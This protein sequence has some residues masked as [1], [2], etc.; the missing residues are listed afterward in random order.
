MK[1]INLVLLGFALSVMSYAQVWQ[2]DSPSLYYVSEGEKVFLSPDY[3]SYAIYFKDT[4]S[5]SATISMKTLSASEDV[6]MLATKS[7]AIVKDLKKPA[8]IKTADQKNSFLVSNELAAAG[9]YDVLP[10]FTVLGQQVWF[11]KRVTLEL[12]EGYDLAD[13]SSLLEQYDATFLRNTLNEKSFLLEVEGIENQLPLIQQLSEQGYLKWGHPDFRVEIVHFNDPLF[14]E[15]F[16][17]NNTGGTLDGNPLV[18]D[19]DIDALEAWGI[20]TGTSSITVSVIDDGLEAHPDLPTISA[21]Y[22]PANNGDGTPTTSTDGH[23]LA[24]GGIIAAQHDNGI[25]VRGVAPG[26]DLIAVNIFQGSETTQDLADA[27]TWSV[28]QGADVISNS[29]GYSSCTFNAPTLTAAINSAATTGRNGLGCVILFASGNDYGS[30]VSYPAN[31]SNVIAVGALSPDGDISLYS[32]QGSA[33]DVV[34]PSNDVNNAVTAFIYGVRT[35]DRVGSNGYSTGEYTTSFGGTSAACPAAAGAAALVLSVDA[36]LTKDQ[37]YTLLTTT[38]DDMGGAGF[39]NT[40]GY[41]RVNAYQAVIAA[42]GISCSLAAP[43]SFT[44][45]NVTDTGFDLSWSAVS[46]AT[47]YTLIIDGSSYA[48]SGTS[49]SATG[50]TPGTTYSCVVYGLCSN[51]GIGSSA[52]LDVTTTGSNCV[53][54]PASM[55]LITDNYGSETTWTLSVDGS[56]VASG[57]PYANNTTYNVSFDYGDGDYD[58]VISDSYGDGICCAYGTGSYTITDG[59]GS[60]IAAGGEF[61]TTDAVS[62]CIEGGSGGGGGCTST[63]VDSNDFESGWGIWNDGGSDCRRSSNDASYSNGTYSIRLRDN[64]NSSVMT[65]DNL[66]L[67]SFDDLTVSF[68][69]YARSMDNSNE[70]FWLQISTDGGSSYTLVE[71]WNLN[72]E[73]VNNVREDDAV[74]IAGPFTSTTR[75][76]FRCDASGNSDWVY[77]DDVEISGC[78]TGTSSVSLTNEVAIESP[79]MAPVALPIS[80][81]PNPVRSVVNLVNVPEQSLVRVLSVSGGVLFEGQGVSQVDLSSFNSGLYILQ[82]Q[83]DDLSQTFRLIKE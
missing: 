50:L 43:S 66:D 10:S 2:D 36:T 64:S 12:N 33:L 44:E 8:T 41:G 1:K 55:V 18:A 72:D 68:S 75:L 9:A 69:Y 38:A 23:G 27:F 57:G 60:T 24:C 37:V 4:P 53:T 70:D 52:T 39:D 5:S 61:S 76:R 80:F 31:L 13:I 56:Q 74:T 45:A 17:M 81:Y 42:G 35:T 28:S 62:F 30:C 71:E 51:G 3:S 46:G 58:F 82:V 14:G 19:M 21:G 7:L 78:S 20:T 63:L 25:G 73:F 49:F 6:K 40:F 83:A 32:N 65:T 67:S 15:Q 47:G 54:G 79:D 77:I 16:Q 26:V 48:V 11:T 34:A 29:W 59:G 22:T